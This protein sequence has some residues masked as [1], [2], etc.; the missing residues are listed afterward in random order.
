MT[1][2]E[3]IRRWREK[4]DDSDFRELAD[5]HFD[6]VRWLVLCAVR[7]NAMTED[8]VQEIFFKV[9]RKLDRFEGKAAFSTWLYRIALNTVNTHQTS[10]R[11]RKT[12][13]LADDDPPQADSA[14]QPDRAAECRELDAAIRDAVRDL[15]D[16]LRNAISLTAMNGFSPTEAAEIEN[17]TLSSMYRRLHDARKILKERLEKFL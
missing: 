5:R 15:P 14:D 17:C 6:Q 10:R 2:E 3:L 7:D 9:A 1:D 8:L 12:Q 16:S 13:P 11:D 4:R